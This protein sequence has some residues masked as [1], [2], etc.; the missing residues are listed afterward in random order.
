MCAH[1]NCISDSGEFSILM[2]LMRMRAGDMYL[3]SLKDRDSGNM[4]V[5]CKIS[6]RKEK[7]DFPF[8]QIMDN[9]V[10]ESTVPAA[11]LG[12]EAKAASFILQ[13][14]SGNKINVCKMIM[15]VSIENNIHIGWAE[16]K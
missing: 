7:Q 14:H 1:G 8:A 10:V 9:Q 11:C 2:K 4:C 12:T 13:I 5:Q 16:S 6:S 3:F 15:S